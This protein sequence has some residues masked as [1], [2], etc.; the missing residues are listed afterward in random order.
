[1]ALKFKKPDCHA[2]FRTEEVNDICNKDVLGEILT[3]VAFE[4]QVAYS[5]HINLWH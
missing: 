1:M 5:V 4:K 3:I 2:F